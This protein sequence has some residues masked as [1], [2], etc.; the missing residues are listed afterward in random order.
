MKNEFTSNEDTSLYADRVDMYYNGKAL[1]ITSDLRL[2]MV[3]G[4]TRPNDQIAIFDT[5]LRQAGLTDFA[6]P[7]SFEFLS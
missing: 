5:P 4:D 3:P 2:A 6:T 7:A 1:A